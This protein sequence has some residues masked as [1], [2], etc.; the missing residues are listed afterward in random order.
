MGK[1]LKCS[2]VIYTKN[3]N[4]NYALVSS[5]VKVFIAMLLNSLV[6]CQRN[7]T[8]KEKL[9]HYAYRLG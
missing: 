7:A 3:F 4:Y 8:L 2:N 1:P 6:V 9:P 5:V